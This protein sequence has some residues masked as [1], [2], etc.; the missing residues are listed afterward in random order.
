MLI[1]ACS[2]NALHP[3]YSM[4]EAKSM[5]TN[6]KKE[7]LQ[8]NIGFYVESLGNFRSTEMKS[9]RKLLISII[10]GVSRILEDAKVAQEQPLWS[11]WKA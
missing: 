7:P 10:F 6:G 8:V 5:P 4:L 11:W 3:I 1:L 9:E 2:L